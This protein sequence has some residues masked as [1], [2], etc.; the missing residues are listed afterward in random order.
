M[1]KKII[2]SSIE[3]FIKKKK[4]KLIRIAIKKQASKE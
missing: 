3:N 2:N 4:R 1:Q